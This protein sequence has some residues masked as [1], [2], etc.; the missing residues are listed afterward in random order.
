MFNYR[1]PAQE[2]VNHHFLRVNLTFGQ[3]SGTMHDKP[4]RVSS[5]QHTVHLSF[6]L[7]YFI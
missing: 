6:T 5:L 4:S 1:R 3:D 2:G 7:S